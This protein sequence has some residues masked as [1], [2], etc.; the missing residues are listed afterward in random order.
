MAITLQSLTPCCLG[1]A[2]IFTSPNSFAST[3]DIST[4][5]YVQGVVNVDLAFRH[6]FV[7]GMLNK[8]PGEKVQGQSEATLLQA[9]VPKNSDI[10]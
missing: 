7:D 1:H 9:C 10:S 8:M 3:I 5:S 4:D 2:F 6:L